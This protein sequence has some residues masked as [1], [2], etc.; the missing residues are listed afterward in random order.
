MGLAA[1]IWALRLEFGTRNWDLR[2]G[3][4]TKEKMRVKAYVI[5]PLRVFAKKTERK[6]ERLM[7]R[8][9]EKIEGIEERKPGRKKRKRKER[10]KTERQDDFCDFRL[11]ML[12]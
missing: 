12:N 5:D 3:R 11:F 7:E 9:K 1:R 4:G 6:D 2:R 10:M 8:K